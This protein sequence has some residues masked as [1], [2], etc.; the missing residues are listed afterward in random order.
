MLRDCCGSDAS[1]DDQ[2]AE[3]IVDDVLKVRRAAKQLAASWKH[4]MEMIGSHHIC[5]VLLSAQ[6]NE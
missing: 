4:L 5:S 6:L 3:G 1:N 2:A